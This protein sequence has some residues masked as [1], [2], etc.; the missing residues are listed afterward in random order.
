LVVNPYDVEGA[1]RALGAALA[2][3]Q[4]ARRARMDAMRR[5]VERED[6][7]WWCR[8]FFTA[9]RAT[10]GGAI[11]GVDEYMPDLREEA[12]TSGLR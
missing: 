1:G 6:V 11:P 10:T 3:G 9:V 8:R 7:F 4:E 12:M 2:M 5:L